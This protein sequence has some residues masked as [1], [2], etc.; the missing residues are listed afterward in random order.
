VFLCSQSWRSK[1]NKITKPDLSICHNKELC[2][3]QFHYDKICQHYLQSI[4]G[5]S[6]LWFFYFLLSSH[7]HRKC[8]STFPRG[9]FNLCLEKR[10]SRGKKTTSVSFLLLALYQAKNKP[11]KALYLQFPTSKTI[12]SACIFH[13]MKVNTKIFSYYLVKQVVSRQL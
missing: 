3:S 5:P 13:K 8:H 11:S 10:T 12:A 7:M 6:L 1:G 4:N 2:S 9:V